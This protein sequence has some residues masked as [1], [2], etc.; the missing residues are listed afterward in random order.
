MRFVNRLL[1]TSTP[2][3]GLVLEHR[4][5]SVGALADLV[6]FKNRVGYSF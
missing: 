6:R 1:I 3:P 2:K 4:E 5:A